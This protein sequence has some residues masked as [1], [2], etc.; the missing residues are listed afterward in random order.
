MNR[1]VL[2]PLGRLFR[3]PAFLICV[4]ILGICAGGLQFC[5]K[6]LEWHLSKL[7]LPLRKPLDQLDPYRIEPYRVV[8][9]QIIPP[10]IE[11]ELGTKEYLNARLEDTSVDEEDPFRQ[12]MFFVTYYTGNPDKVPHV[13]DVCY[14]GSGGSLRESRNTWFT[15]PDCGAED[16]RLPVRNLTISLPSTMERMDQEVFYF[17]AVNGTYRCTRDSVRVLQHNLHDRYAYFSKIEITF[18]SANHASREDQF[19]A[20]ERVARVILPVLYHEHLPDWEAATA[21]KRDQ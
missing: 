13:P 16:N 7:P 2:E 3:Q 19:K 14:I 20:A 21:S 9:R 6:K 1:Y 8:H 5:I 15:V 12:V 10:E 4:L 18:P 11:D 17:F